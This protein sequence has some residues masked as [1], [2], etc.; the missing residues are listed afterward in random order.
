MNDETTDNVP[1]VDSLPLGSDTATVEEQEEYLHA[2]QYDSNNPAD[3]PGY[4][5]GQA[6]I[7]DHDLEDLLD[8]EKNEANASWNNYTNGNEDLPETTAAQEALINT[9]YSA[10]DISN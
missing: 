8:D 4:I 1:I 3:L 2:V 6:N 5:P 9:F 7:I 10:P